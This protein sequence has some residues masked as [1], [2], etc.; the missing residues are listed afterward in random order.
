[1]KNGP[2]AREASPEIF[3]RKILNL[4]KI[5]FLS[6]E[7][8]RAKIPGKESDFWILHCVQNDRKKNLPNYLW[9]LTGKIRRDSTLRS[10]RLSLINVL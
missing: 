6:L 4:E 10:D 3:A 7:E 2:P 9:F 1:L 8:A 5:D